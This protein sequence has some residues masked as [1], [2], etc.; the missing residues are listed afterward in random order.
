MKKRPRGTGFNSA[1][2][3]A[4]IRQK[5]CWT[6][7]FRVKTKFYC[8]RIRWLNVEAR[9]SPELP[10]EQAMRNL[11]PFAVIQNGR[12][13][14]TI[15]AYSLDQARAIVAARLADTTGIRIVAQR[16]GSPR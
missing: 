2:S 7:N 10:Q 13:I 12:P 16:K 15:H 14:F 1:L 3:E 4:A 6:T 9:G 5:P 11:Q 8:M